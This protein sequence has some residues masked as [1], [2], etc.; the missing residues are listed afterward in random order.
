VGFI[1][2]E[3]AEKKS[4]TTYIS[5]ADLDNKNK[6]RAGKE[7]LTLLSLWNE[8]GAM[9]KTFR[10]LLDALLEAWVSSFV[11][12][13]LEKDI[14]DALL[15]LDEL[16]EKEK[17]QLEEALRV[18]GKERLYYQ[19]QKLLRILTRSRDTSNDIVVKWAF[20]TL[21]QKVDTDHLRFVAIC[22]SACGEA[23]DYPSQLEEAAAHHIKAAAQTLKVAE[24][25]RF[26]DVRG[27][28][29][30]PMDGTLTLRTSTLVDYVWVTSK[31]GE[32]LEKSVATANE[33]L[34][35]AEVQLLVQ[36]GSREMR[37]FDVNLVVKIYPHIKNWFERREE[38]V[39]LETVSRT[40]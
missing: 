31:M 2:L 26:A 27:G 36:L 6:F 40:V 24:V 38:I 3:S 34:S 12:A 5:D 39:T 11:D 21:G 19:P 7:A 25:L 10:V 33:W 4:G 32:T 28:P 17:G 30:Q 15:A 13:K 14:V 35:V 37:G 20:R 29:Y 22:L 18:C 23:K 9:P 1:L 16:D 8:G